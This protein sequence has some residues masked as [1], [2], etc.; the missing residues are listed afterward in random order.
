MQQVTAIQTTSE[1]A[2]PTSTA[3]AFAAITP[4]QLEDLG[5]T[6]EQVFFLTYHEIADQEHAGKKVWRPIKD[7]VTTTELEADVMAG[8]NTALEA[9]KLFYEGVYELGQQLD[10]AGTTLTAAAA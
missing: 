5:L 8:L 10:A 1:G 4:A 7:H 6:E 2:S 9:H 3:R